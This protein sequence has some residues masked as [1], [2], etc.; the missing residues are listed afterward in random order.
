MSAFGGWG[1]PGTGAIQQSS[2]FELTW[3]GD[4]AKGMVLEQGA[5]YSGAIRD[6]GNTPTTVIRG[7]LLVGKLTASG[8]LE[9]WDAD[10]ADGTEHLFGVVPHEIRAQDFDATN[11]DRYAGVIVRAPLK[12]KSLLIQGDALVGHQDEYLARRAL[13]AM[14]C[15]IDDDPQ[16]FKAGAGGRQKAVAAD[17]TVL[18]SENGTTFVGHTADNEFTLPAIKPGLSFSFAQSADFELKVTSSEGDNIIGGND[19]SGDSITFTTAGEQI[20]AQVCFESINV[21]GTLKWL[22]HIKKVAFSTDDFFAYTF[23]T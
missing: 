21:N 20:G 23:A 18:A 13:H 2:E 14:G 22:Y 15:I 7:G 6:A 10:A 17:H 19:A 5:N 1:N 4:R 12:A 11:A 16:G 8:K 3:G 9:E